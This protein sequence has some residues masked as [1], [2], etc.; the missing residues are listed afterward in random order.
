MKDQSKIDADQER[1]PLAYS[2]WLGTFL[3]RGAVAPRIIA[4]V[5]GFGLLA[6]ATIY[7]SQFATKNFQ[8][9]LTVPARPFEVAG[10]VLALLLVLRL[11]AG[12]DRWWEAR[13]LW[14]GVV[15]QSRNLAIAGLAYGPT[16]KHWRQSF[17][18]WVASFPHVMRRSLRGEHKLPELANLLSD[19]QTG[20][21]L[22]K[23]HMP[24]AVSREIASLLAEAKGNGWICVPRSGASARYFD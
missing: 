10:A 20:W 14:G 24:D 1:K 16:E 2:Y 6:S 18:K 12:H 5:I 22:S 7:A 17:I 3:L 19:D 21:L 4:D 8:I 15:N 11:N 23:E 13:K 9:V